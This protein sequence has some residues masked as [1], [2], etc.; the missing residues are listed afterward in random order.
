[1]IKPEVFI[2]QLK[3]AGLAFFTGVPDSLLKSLCAYIADVLPAE[4]H[5]ITANEGNAVALAAGHYLGSGQPAVVYM[6]NSGL[7][8]TINPIT[9]LVD[10]EVYSIPM[11][12]IIGW[13]GEPGI[14]DEPQHVKQGLVTLA[15]LDVLDVPYVVI[16]ADSDLSTELPVLL[17][18]MNTQ[19]RPVAVVVRK[20]TFAAY[21]ST[22]VDSKSKLKREQALLQLLS[23]FDETDLVVSTT[24]K[25]SREVFEIR[26]NA[27]QQAR[28]FL[29]V[30]AMGHT[31]SIAMGV[32]MTNPNKRVIAL[33]GDGSLLMHMGAMPV[34]GNSGLKNL[35]HVVL[36][37]GC[38]ESV[39]GQPTVAQNIDL[40][41]MSYGAGYQVYM[42]AHDEASLIDCI[43][44]LK[45]LS[46]PVMLE[47]LIAPG[48]RDD[49]GRPTSTPVENKVAFMKHVGCE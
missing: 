11:L 23:Q 2:Q 31:A 38:H 26:V 32:A 10:P 41:S 29:T 3:H 7:G 40:K 9:S 21:S 43:E 22:P 39:G 5:V 19:T 48:S 33:D 45:H 17:E 18:A 49:L 30:G 15:Q 46:G 34:I 8:N 13:R 12:M 6:Q 28:D 16:D 20:G 42:Q 1:M 44:R 24:G 14:K 25:T 37:N 4:Q 36:N 35:V 27:D 47:V